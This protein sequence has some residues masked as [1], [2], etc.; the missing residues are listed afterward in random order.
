MNQH[1]TCGL[2]YDSPSVGP[3]LGSDDSKWLGVDDGVDVDEGV[4]DG[5]R[6]GPTLGVDEGVVEGR[7]VGLPLGSGDGIAEGRDVGIPLG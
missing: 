2:A 5:R 1:A 7:I 6:V 4:V 3:L